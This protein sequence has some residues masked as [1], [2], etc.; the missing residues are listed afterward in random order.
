MKSDHET[1]SRPNSPLR[2]ARRHRRHRRRL[3]QPHATPTAKAASASAWTSSGGTILVYEM[4]LSKMTEQA[5]QDLIDSPNSWPPRSS[6]AS[7]RPTCTT[8]PSAPCRRPAA[9][10]DHPADRRPSPVQR[11]AGGLAGL[12][13]QVKRK[14]PTWPSP[15]ATSR[16]ASLPTSSAASPRPTPSTRKGPRTRR[17]MTSPARTSRRRRSPTSST[18]WRRR[19]TSARTFTG[20]EVE[21]IKNLIQQQG[22]LEFRIL[23]NNVDDKDAIDAAK[24][25]IQNRPERRL[26]TA[27][28]RGQAAAAADPERHGERRPLLRRQPQRREPSATSTAGSSW[29]RRSCTP[30]SST[31]PPKRPATPTRPGGR[32]G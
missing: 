6:A 10:R 11:R 26:D 17:A 14:I 31:A 5:R 15:T 29:A 21:N 13:D 23:A 20:E 3:G 27:Q 32:S 24:T 7:T 2:R 30:C 4:D 9:R 18:A 1:V 25:Y 12:I 8:S 16:R 28:R 22:R 19:A